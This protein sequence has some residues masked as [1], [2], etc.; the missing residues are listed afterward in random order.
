MINNNEKFV[1]LHLHTEYSISD[2]IITI[3]KLMEKSKEENNSSVAITDHNNIF[4]A[5]KLYKN[6]LKNKIKPIIGCEL[7]I[8]NKDLPDDIKISNILLL[9]QN[10]IGYKNLSYLLS[11]GYYNKPISYQRALI[12]FELIKNNSS[13]LIALSCGIEGNI[14]KS[15]INGYSNKINNYII[16]SWMSIFNDRFYIEISRVGKSLEDEYIEKALNLANIKSIPIVATNNTHFIEKEDF[17]AHEIKV[18]IQNSEYYNDKNRVSAYTENQYLKNDSE[19]R[20]IFLDIPEAIQNSIEISKRCSLFLDFNSVHLPVFEF[21]KNKKYVDNSKYLTEE[22]EKYLNKYL[23]KEFSSIHVDE[24]N[25]KK[26]IYF[27]RLSLELKVINDMG[28]SS[29]FLIV[30]DF[31]NWAK[32]N[33]IAVG[34]GRGSGAGSLVAFVVGITTIDPI[35]YELLFE[36]FLN[37]ERIGLPDLDI[38]FCMNGRDKVIDYVFNK[39]GRDKVA[40]IITYGTM[41]AKAVIRDVGRV[42]GYN[43]GFVDR[44]AKLIPFE[45]GVTIDKALK[46]EILLKE[47]Y[48]KEQDAAHIIDL[49]KKLE[50]IIRNIGKHAG[51]VIISPSPIINFMPLYCD[52]NEKNCITQFDKDDIE[53]IG[54]IKFDFLSLRTLTI[55]SSTIKKINKTLNKSTDS[56]NQI[57]IE[58]IEYDDK[59]TFDML[60]K[61]KT[62]GVFQL[63]S[64]GMRDLIKR[65]KPDSFNDIVA[66]VALFRPGPLQ[67]GMVDDY[68]KRK[69][70]IIPIGSL[71]EKIDEILIPTYGVI[72]YQEQII[73]ITQK[74]TKW[75]LGEAD[76]LRRAISKKNVTEMTSLKSKFI[77]SATEN[78][79]EDWI[80]NKIFELIEKFAG[81]GFNKSHS[82]AY[83]KIAYQ[84]AWLKANFC[85]EFMTSVLSSEIDNTDK[86]FIYISECLKLGIKILRPDINKSA[87]KFT[88]EEAGKVRYAFGAIKGVGI[89]AAKEIVLE[90]HKNGNFKNFID[91]CYR[92]SAKKIN[93]R[94]IEMLVKCGAFDSF[95]KNRAALFNSINI[96][97]STINK[98]SKKSFLGQQDLFPNKSDTGEEFLEVD[99][100]HIKWT[101]DEIISAERDSFGFLFSINPMDIYKNELINIITDNIDNL[102]PVSRKTIIL[103]GIIENIKAINTKRG[104]KMAFITID[105]GTGKIDIP[106]FSDTYYKNIDILKL[107]SLIVIECDISAVKSNDSYRIMAR[108]IILLDDYRAK[109]AKKINIKIENEKFSEEI[110]E[111]L[112]SLFERY[113]NGNCSVVIDYYKKNIMIASILLEKK[114]KITPTKQFINDINKLIPNIDLMYTY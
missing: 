90:R 1:H 9:C 70:K 113:N 18:C 19:M 75:S 58:K 40:Q 63:E 32:N 60:Y 72:L 21:D 110:L 77:K 104:E 78:G 23:N 64:R 15:L 71:H 25:N 111:N 87:H 26:K 98:G 59:K 7:T 39:Y 35:K 103:A 82:V 62:I 14:G 105:D 92:M 95:E 20:K 91:F 67:S 16:D 22:S 53:S 76:L 85:D 12:D 28:F 24:F 46:S 61:C 108:K 73:K 8:Y 65:L 112:E 79:I 48:K 89:A 42:L 36:R 31:I 80:S 11:N 33:D 38:D 52:D 68:I 66:L 41:S 56:N 49:A 88:I 102:K 99:R 86:I 109:F 83:A 4:S 45:V 13:G 107:N 43:Y 10:K 6:S 5:V 27:D 57:D 100:K 50:G 34:P 37:P 74:L 2:G 96:I 54:L 30:S 93:K 114:W 97:L 84:T 55:I 69:H 94:V 51:G 47:F 17:Q 29:Y 101:M 3:E 106:V 81:Y 44:I